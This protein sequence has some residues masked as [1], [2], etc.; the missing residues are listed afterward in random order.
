MFAYI[1]T[2][3]ATHIAIH[4]PQE[5][6]EKSL[7]AL[8][9][10]LE[11]NAVFINNCPYS[12]LETVKPE[13]TFKLGDTITAEHRDGELL[14]AVPESEHIIDS[15]FVLAEPAV[16]VSNKAAAEKA[17]K[18]IIDLQTELAHVKV[19][20]EQ[21]KEAVAAMVDAEIAPVT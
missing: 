10:L 11:R 15:S 16:F 8:I 1:K 5:G 21:A 12:R 14:I 2:N 7:P 18:Q 13:I 9:G 17:S 4:V 20:L 19:Q 6:A 3:G